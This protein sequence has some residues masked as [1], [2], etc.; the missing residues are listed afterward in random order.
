MYD[1][2]GQWLVQQHQND[3]RTHRST[4]NKTP[5]MNTSCEQL[6]ST[7]LWRVH[8]GHQLLRTPPAGLDFNHNDLL[9]IG[10]FDE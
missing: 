5:S 8:T 6:Q 2:T 7:Q 4:S 3:V 10:R 9:A 1:S